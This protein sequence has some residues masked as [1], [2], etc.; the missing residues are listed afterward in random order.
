MEQRFWDILAKKLCKENPEIENRERLDNLIKKAY[1]DIS[2]KKFLIYF[3][4]RIMP[5]WFYVIIRNSYRRV[6]IK[7]YNRVKND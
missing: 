5:V 6:M 4:Y 1:C 7:D 3:I 2:G